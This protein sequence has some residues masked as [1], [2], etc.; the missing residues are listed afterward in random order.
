MPSNTEFVILELLTGAAERYGLELVRISHGKLKR[1]SVYVLLDRLERAGLVESRRDTNNPP[2]RMYRLSAD[3]GR[4][5]DARRLL[6]TG[7]VEVSAC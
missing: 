4:A 3:G 1:G 2:R 7:A 5:L 6:E